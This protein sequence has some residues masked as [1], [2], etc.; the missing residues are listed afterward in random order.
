[1]QLS[2]INPN[3][4]KD[5]GIKV[6]SQYRFDKEELFDNDNIKWIFYGEPYKHQ[7]NSEGSVETKYGLEYSFGYIELID[8]PN[9][10]YD[11]IYGLLIERINSDLDNYLSDSESESD[12]EYNFNKKNKK[13]RIDGLSKFYKTD[14]FENCEIFMDEFNYMDFESEYNSSKIK[15]KFIGNPKNELYKYGFN[16]ATGILIP[17]DK[18]N[19]KFKLVRG[20]ITILDDD[21]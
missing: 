20:F 14:N 18:P 17:V 7:V 4:L 10:K 12:Y 2:I 1:M 8:N 15:Y 21:L 3:T 13:K 11:V 9:I 6:D 16:Y 19:I 5:P